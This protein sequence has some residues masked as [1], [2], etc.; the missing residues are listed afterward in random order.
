MRLITK[1]F[2]LSKA[3]YEWEV[4]GQHT[5]ARVAVHLQNVQGHSDLTDSCV[6][7]ITT[8]NFPLNYVMTCEPQ[9]SLAQSGIGWPALRNHIQCIVHVIERVLC[10][11]M[12]SPDVNCRNKSW[13]AHERDSHVGENERIDMTSKTWRCENQQGL[14]HQTRCSRDNL[15]SRYFMIFW[16]CWTWPSYRRECMQYWLCWHLF[17][18]TSSL[19]VNMLKSATLCFRLWMRRHVRTE[20]WWCSS[21]L[22]VYRNLHVSCYKI[23][24]TVIT[25]HLCQLKMNESLWSM[26]YK[27]W[28]HFDIG[29]GE[30]WRGIQSQCLTTS[31]YSMPCSIIPM[32]WCE[33]WPRRMLQRRKTWCLLWC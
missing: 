10:A 32:V 1:S 29:P 27:Y 7:G 2:P 13:E 4:K 17:G 21:A 22:T 14:R 5:G 24:N 26:S 28:G 33:P 3:Y 8:Y 9:S 16:K 19:S 11:F 31:Q 20:P 25:R 30:C 12:S 23:Q 6:S 15:Q 18:K